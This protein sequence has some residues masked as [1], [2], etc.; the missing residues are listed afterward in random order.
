LRSETIDALIVD[1]RIPDMRGDALFELG[2]AMQPHLRTHT[3]IT[4]GDITERAA[5]IIAA[6]KCSF[7]KKPFD[8]ADLLRLVESLVKD[9]RDGSAIA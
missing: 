6:C 5:E 7:M 1:L 4:T 9:R 8:L 3:I 2:S